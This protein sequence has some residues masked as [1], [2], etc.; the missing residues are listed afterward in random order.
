MVMFQLLE[1]ISSNKRKL[2]YYGVSNFVLISLDIHKHAHINLN[3]M[4]ILGKA[5]C[6]N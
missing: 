4:L 3:K 1:F 5:S 2:F 6:V